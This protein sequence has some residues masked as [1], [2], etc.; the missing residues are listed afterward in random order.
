MNAISR[1]AMRR[2][3]GML[4]VGVLAVL[5]ALAAVQPVSAHPE[6]EDG[7]GARRGTSGAGASGAAAESSG[8]RVLGHAD[9]G[10]GFHADV[11]AHGNHAYLSSW[12]AGAARCP[13]FG[14]RVFGLHDPSNPV[15]VSTFA[16]GANEPATDGSWTEKVIV[17]SV[18]NQHFRG[19]LAVVSFQR[20][21]GTGH[22]GFGLYDVSDPANPQQLA[23]VPTAANGSHEIWLEVRG[24]RAYVYTAVINAELVTNREQADFQ[25]WDVSDPT[26]PTFVSQWGAWEN[27]GIEPRF[28]DEQ[29]VTRSNFVHSVIGAVVGNQHRAYLSHWDLGTIILDVTDPTN[30]TFIGRSEF[31]P[32][33]E[34]NA[35]SAW[36]ARGG[37]LLIQTDEDFNPGP[38]P[39]GALEQAWG[40]PRFFDISDPSNPEQIGTFE[41]ATTRQA[42]PDRPGD[43]TVHD[44]KVRG[45][46]VYFS[47]YAEGVVMVDISDP[48][49]PRQVA[50][51]LPPPAEDPFGLFV[52]A[53]VNVWGVTLNRDYVL[54]SDMSSGLW[55][56]KLDRSS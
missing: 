7:K 50:Q 54:A 33:E 19:D 38:H 27:L 11:V 23:L 52:P 22:R 15:H 44:P 25:I 37:N 51:F 14:V 2:H 30:P 12:G 48:T 39:T 13:S 56:F 31:A 4:L 41:L 28:V 16:D 53:Q 35:H 36:L 42:S 43:F 21:R 29:G 45:N 47:W 10:G 6:D 1:A 46:T 34:G 32:D 24:A 17:Q 9:P 49:A 20:C 18:A 8:V 55:V 40:Y 3:A 5:L 26:T